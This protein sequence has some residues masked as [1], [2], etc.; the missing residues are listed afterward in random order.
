MFT[1]KEAHHLLNAAAQQLQPV[2]IG[3][4]MD[5]LSMDQTGQCVQQEK[6]GTTF[7]ER[8]FMQ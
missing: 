6:K 3:D 1:E 2:L 5:T 8:C 7:V 4:P